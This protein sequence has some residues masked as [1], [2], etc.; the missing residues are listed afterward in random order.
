MF[1]TS[2]F[3]R[4]GPQTRSRRSHS[5][6]LAQLLKLQGKVTNKVSNLL[7]ILLTGAIESLWCI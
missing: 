4:S 3:R 2:G 7:E 6:S 1:G 5:S